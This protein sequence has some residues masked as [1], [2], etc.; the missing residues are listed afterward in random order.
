VRER[1]A[2]AVGD[3]LIALGVFAC[4]LLLVRATTPHLTFGD[5]YG[6]LD[7]RVYAAMAAQL[8]GQPPVDLPP[9]YVFRILPVWLV[10]YSGADYI[11]AFLTM[12]MLGFAAA[13]MLLF[14][15]L[16]SY[17]VSRMSSA[18]AVLWWLLLPAGLRLSWYYP[19][20]V[21]GIGLAFLMALLLIAV[22]GWFSLFALMF[23][24]A[25]LT[26][27]NL[28]V[29]VPFLMLA[30]VRRGWLR[31]VVAAL[32]ASLPG[33]I[34]YEVARLAPLIVPA[35]P[36]DVLGD[37]R[38]NL[39]WLRENA[40]ERAW[41]YMAAP[42]L[43]LGMVLTLPIARLGHTLRLLSREPAWA[44]YLAV[45]LVLA[46][47]GGGDYD[48]FMLWLAPAFLVLGFRGFQPTR[49][50]ALAALLGVLSIVHVWLVRAT[51]PLTSDEHSYRQFVVA[52]MPVP[53]LVAQLAVTLTVMAVTVTGLAYAAARSTR[54]RIAR[55]APT[56]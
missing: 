40:A 37:I 7:G 17:E 43:T 47:I 27:E 14:A 13:T 54:R 45:T 5:G 26:R 38:Q 9:E 3:A 8:R 19:V 2:G 15:L 33:L 32:A 36:P 56:T 29:L 55:D 53:V 6:F 48:R 18:V 52:L 10:A 49:G 31:A 20:I 11:P 35:E 30:Q 21:D 22:R 50:W 41:R 25:V 44:Y 39:Q 24:L 16:R 1:T 51:A 4:A 46:A 12:N 42:F 34:V 28:V 23:P